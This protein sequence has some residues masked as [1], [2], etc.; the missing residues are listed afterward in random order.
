MQ[1]EFFSVLIPS[2]PA[3]I[4]RTYIHGG[5]TVTYT[6]DVRDWLLKAGHIIGARAG[7][8]DFGVDESKSYFLWMRWGGRRHDVDAHIKLVQDAIF[9]K[10]NANDRVVA[11]VLIDKVKVDEEF[12][13]VFLWERNFVYVNISNLS[14]L[15]QAPD[16]P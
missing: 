1:S 3:G 12:V 4:N 16:K 9:E 10:L 5:G 14:A 13:E 11:S 15:Y 6:K 7:V 8:L 2:V